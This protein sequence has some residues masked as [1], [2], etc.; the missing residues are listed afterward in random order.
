MVWL[1]LAIAIASEVMATL[2]LKYCDNFSKPTPTVL[3]VVGYASAF[4]FLAKILNM[5]P[6]SIAYAIWSGVGVTLVAIIGW[7]WLGQKLDIAAIIGVTLIVCGVVIINL[8][9]STVIH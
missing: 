1:Y 9:S 4:F 8:F 2:S 6:V 5:I 7:L 3:V